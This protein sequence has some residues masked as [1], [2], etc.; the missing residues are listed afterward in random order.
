MSE[1]RVITFNRMPNI[2]FE[3]CGLDIEK[4][5]MQAPVCECGCGGKASIV[6][7]D[8]SDVSQFCGQ[9]CAENDCNQCAVFVI[10]KDNSLIGA[11]KLGNDIQIIGS[12]GSLDDYETL[13][14]IADEFE[15][16]CYGL[17]CWIKD[18]LYYVV[19][20]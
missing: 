18:N 12:T 20:K 7:N 6:L 19:E 16:H 1:S 5:F 8:Q 3:K 10:N 2:T 17:I 13:G 15:L 11:I 9:M 14:E 4:N